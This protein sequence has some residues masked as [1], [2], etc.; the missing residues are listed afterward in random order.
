MANALTFIYGK[1]LFLVNGTKE[2]SN[3]VLVSFVGNC[4]N[5]SFDG[6]LNQF[7]IQSSLKF[8]AVWTRRMV[9]GFQV[10]NISSEVENIFDREDA[11]TAK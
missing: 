3:S 8:Q 1:R 2:G 10:S 4:N 9:Q 5:S 11:A 7:T 6:K